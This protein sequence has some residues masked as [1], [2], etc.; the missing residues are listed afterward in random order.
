MNAMRMTDL[1][2]LGLGAASLAGKKIN[3]RFRRLEKF[4]ECRCDELKIFLSEAEKRGLKEKEALKFRIRKK[5]GEAAMELDL[6]TREDIRDIKKDI[7]ETI[8][9]KNA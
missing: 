8:K 1:I 5:A 6:A 2:Y 9:N 3:A 4:K 7:E